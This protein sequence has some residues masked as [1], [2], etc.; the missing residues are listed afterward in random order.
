[1]GIG[2]EPINKIKK[3]L[4]EFKKRFLNEI[5]A[6]LCQKKCNYVYRFMILFDFVSQVHFYNSQLSYWSLHICDNSW[7]AYAHAKNVRNLH[8]NK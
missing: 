6:T 4:H 5:Q 1:M 8:S 3:Q 2:T 7:Y